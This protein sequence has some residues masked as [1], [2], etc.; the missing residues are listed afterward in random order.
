MDGIIGGLAALGSSSRTGP[1]HQKD[2]GRIRGLGLSASHYI[3]R[4]RAR[5]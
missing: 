5:G 3:V 4:E 1:G 2:P